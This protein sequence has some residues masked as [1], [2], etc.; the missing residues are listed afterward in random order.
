M[1]F[2]LIFCL[3]IIL[4]ANACSPRPC[5]DTV[6][7]VGRVQICQDIR[8]QLI[9]LNSNDPTLYPFEYRAANWVSPTRQ[10]LLLRKYREFECDKVLNECVPRAVHCL[11]RTPQPDV[12]CKH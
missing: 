1:Q 7:P 12:S 4:L 9:F 2:R 6:P 10:A 3:F 8:K 5:K 11:G